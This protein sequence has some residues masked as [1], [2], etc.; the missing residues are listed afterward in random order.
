ME[1][2]GNP[3]FRKGR[4]QKVS[5]GLCRLKAQ[6]GHV[7]MISTLILLAM[8][9]LGVVMMSN[10]RRSAAA[11]ANKKN[12]TRAFYASDAIM[13][14]LT[15]EVIDGNERKYIEG[16]IFLNGT[17]LGHQGDP[18]IAGTYVENSGYHTVTA[19]GSDMWNNED[20]GHFAYTIIDGDLDVV[21]K[22]E[23]ISNTNDW[24]KAGIMLR[25]NLGASSP[26]VFVCL[27]PGKGVSRQY[28]AVENANCSY[29]RTSSPTQP[30]YIRLVRNGNDFQAYES[31][32]GASWNEVSSTVTVQLPGQVYAGMAVTS[33][34][35]D[36]SCE[37]SFSEVSGL[38]SESD[39][40]GSGT[41]EVDLFAVD[42]MVKRIGSS[43]FSISTDAYDLD[44]L[45]NKRFSAP[46]SQVL[47]RGQAGGYPPVQHQRV[48][49]YDY[50]YENS[51]FNNC[52]CRTSELITGMVAGAISGERKPVATGVDIGCSNPPQGS[53]C[54]GHLNVW[55]APSSRTVECVFR[56]LTNEWTGLV[57]AHEVLLELEEDD[58]GLV[59]IA[60]VDGDM[61][62]IVYHDSLAF[63]LIDETTGTYQYDNDDFFPLENKGFDRIDEN[64]HDSLNFSFTMEMHSK[65]IYRGGE[66][67]TFR[68]DDDVWVF[69]NDQLAIDM[70]GIHRY[71]ERT[72]ELDNI[73]SSHGLTIGNE[74][75]FDFFFAERHKTESHCRITTNMDIFRS[76]SAQRS[77]K[78]D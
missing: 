23:S 2:W 5:C 6:R 42:Y 27:T 78:R 21:V 50:H 41:W 3:G 48:I 9:G 31:D 22:V 61:A 77:W 43:R 7:L 53:P 39:Q 19:S 58:P 68:G 62:N 51:D 28:R 25:S 24:A 29:D 16:E 26:H 35:N 56:P 55:Y 60:W 33:H 76:I 37:A 18:S 66:S 70:G 45:G 40:V 15:Q 49:Y 64:M 4:V 38:L 34:D 72:V 67:F 32:D 74:Y 54:S 11:A 73:A 75:W 14:L 47:E 59:S 20:H 52:L 36:E 10:A 1:F 12:S 13:T 69:I 17:D 8:T 71:K 65:F 57:P 46:L 63:Q 30:H 44:A